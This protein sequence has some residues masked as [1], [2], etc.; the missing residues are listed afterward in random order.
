LEIK[1]MLKDNEKIIYEQYNQLEEKEEE[2][3][4]LKK[5][6]SQV[7]EKK[8]EDDELSNQKHILQNK[9]KAQR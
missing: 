3:E 1:E 4:K 9:I 8:K 7:K 2:I 5:E 6:V